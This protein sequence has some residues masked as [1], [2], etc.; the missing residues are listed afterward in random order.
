MRAC[1]E[2]SEQPDWRKHM[3]Q[4]QVPVLAQTTPEVCWEACARM[5]WQWR[6]KNLNGYAAKAGS[7][8]SKKTGLTQM[9][10]DAFYQ[11][12]GLRSLTGAKGANM[13]HALGWSP[14]IFTSVD[15]VAG[16]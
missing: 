13:R 4:W 7:W 11:L 8:A 9:Q 10:M 3:A 14:V 12:L 16:H 2:G 15:Q 6:F 5:M 1:D